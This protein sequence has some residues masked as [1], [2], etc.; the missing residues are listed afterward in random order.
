[1]NHWTRMMIYKESL[2]GV[3]DL[4]NLKITFLSLLSKIIRNQRFIIVKQGL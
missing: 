3:T 2:I 1:M 4:R